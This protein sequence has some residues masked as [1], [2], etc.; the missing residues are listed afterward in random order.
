MLLGAFSC[1]SLKALKMCWG[2]LCG[3]SCRVNRPAERQSCVSSLDSLSSL[4][5]LLWIASGSRVC[6]SVC[7]KWTVFTAVSTATSKHAI[8]VC[9]TYVRYRPLAS[10]CKALCTSLQRQLHSHTLA[11][12]VEPA[13]R[14]QASLVL[15]PL[16][17]LLLPAGACA[18]WGAWLPPS[19]GANGAR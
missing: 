10:G 18:K 17:V 15:L 1:R 19:C 7:P 3:S 11:D 8:N 13:V 14:V 16:L 6:E 5:V 2:Y 9:Q 4:Q 12:S